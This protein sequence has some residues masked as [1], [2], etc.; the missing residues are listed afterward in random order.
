M[1]V[2]PRGLGNSHLKRTGL[3][4][5]NFEKNL[6]EVPTM[7]N[8]SV[9]TLGSNIR[10]SS[11]LTGHVF[12]GFP[13][14]PLPTPKQCW[15][16]PMS[17]TAQIA[18]S[19]QHWFTLQFCGR[20]LKFFGPLRN[21]NSKTTDKLTLSVLNC[22]TNDCFEYLF[23]VKVAI[24]YL[25]SYLLWLNISS[26]KYRENPAVDLLRLNTLTVK[27]K[28]TAFFLS[29]GY[30]EHSCPFLFDSPPLLLPKS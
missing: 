19:K 23:L 6:E 16:L 30:E 18:T 3:L 9:E 29:R 27:R 12:P 15:F 1:W 4:V 5:R 8:K 21:T 11:V 7:R 28:I 20:S 25:L 22:V 10:L 17:S 2:K 26:K 24:K 13:P 14:P